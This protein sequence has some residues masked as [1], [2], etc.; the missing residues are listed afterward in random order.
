MF[1]IN[2]KL[3]FGVEVSVVDDDNDAG[4]QDGVLDLGE[5][6]GEVLVVVK[7][8]HE[9]VIRKIYFN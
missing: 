4:G 3:D 1:K 2:L 8:V 9:N 5:A 7:N 6:L